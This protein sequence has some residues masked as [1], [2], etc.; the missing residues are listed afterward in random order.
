MIGQSKA[1]QKHMIPGKEVESA[2]EN[3]DVNA[4]RPK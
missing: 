3:N 1:S 2:I 4:K